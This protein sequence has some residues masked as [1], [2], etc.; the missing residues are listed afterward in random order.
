MNSN[1]TARTAVAPNKKKTLSAAGTRGGP[2]SRKKD[3]D[4]EDGNFEDEA[5]PGWDPHPAARMASKDFGNPNTA[6]YQQKRTSVLAVV[7]MVVQN[8]GRI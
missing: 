2:R 8:L 1:M 3:D 6:R 4:K 7:P 5:S